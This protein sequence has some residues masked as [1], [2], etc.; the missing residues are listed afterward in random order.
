MKKI[1]LL[2]L[3]SS[4]SI[5]SFVYAGEMGNEDCAP[6]AFASLEGGYTG[7]K[8][9]GLELTN[10]TSSVTSEKKKTQT[11]VRLAAG[12]ISMIDDQFGIT[13]ELGWGYYGQTTFNFPVTSAIVGSSLSL[14][15]EHSLY[16]FDALIGASFIQTYYSLYFKVGGLIQ[17]LQQNNT[18]VYIDPNL[19]PNNYS[20]NEKHN[21]TAVLPALKLGAAYNIDSNWSITGS[22]LLA[23]GATTGTTITYTPS[24][25]NKLVVD[26]N[27]QNPT[28]NTFMIGIQYAA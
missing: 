15:S 8:I 5:S 7:N 23:Y 1:A 17:N 26:V 24:A 25:I 2:S 21:S 4:V 27:T 13:G 16:G 6:T 10:V 9:N 19:N 12:V 14:S 3:I 20:L 11:S 22:Y 28:M 18:S